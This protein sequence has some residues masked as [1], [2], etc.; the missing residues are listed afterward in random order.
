MSGTNEESDVEYLRRVI[1]ESGKSI[2][3]V[4]REAGTSPAVMD[5]VL[6]KRRKLGVDLASRLA[7][8]LDIDLI[9]FL[10]GVQVLPPD[11]TNNKNALSQTLLQVFDELAPAQKKQLIEIAKT[12][13]AHP[14]G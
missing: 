9:E 14:P 1:H 10:V 2:A 8:A 12:L 13:A 6:S 11:T 5:A 7:K 3:K 4:A